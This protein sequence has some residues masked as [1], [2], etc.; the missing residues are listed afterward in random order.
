MYN[1]TLP[2]HQGLLHAPPWVRFGFFEW[3]RLWDR[4]SR[5]TTLPG[6]Q[7][8]I[9][10]QSG[11]KVKLVKLRDLFSG[12]ATPRL[13]QRDLHRTAL[14]GRVG[15][16]ILLH[17]IVF[18]MMMILY[19]SNQ[20]GEFPWMVAILDSSGQLACGGSLVDEWVVL[21]SASNFSLSEDPNIDNDLEDIFPDTSK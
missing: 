7:V 1:N 8:E 12:E 5:V 6:K 14:R 18:W 21:V 11:L 16:N 10:I 4:Y 20:Q 13:W 9:Q 17:F 3:R 19:Y 15:S 2:F